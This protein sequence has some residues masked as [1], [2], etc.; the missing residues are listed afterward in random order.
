MFEGVRTRR[1]LIFMFGCMTLLGLWQARAQDQEEEPKETRIYRE[2]YERLQKIVAI[3]DGQRKA[4]A[5]LVFMKERPDSKVMDYAQGN[6]LQVIDSTSKAEKYPAVVQLCERLLKVRPRVGEAYYYYGAALK[7]MQRI[8]EAMNAL[9][10]C[11]L[12]KNNASRRANEFL[13]YI[14]QNQNKGSLIGLDKIKKAA[15]EELNK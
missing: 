4:D 13:E 8:P 1:R 7:N 12:I 2:D 14:Y 15:Q 5:L 10:K 3:A 11:T 6:Y 9:A